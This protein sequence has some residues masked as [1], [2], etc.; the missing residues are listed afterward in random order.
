ML[1]DADSNTYLYY[2]RVVSHMTNGLVHITHIPE[3][4]I[5]SW[6]DLYDR[7]GIKIMVFRFNELVT[8]ANTHSTPM[9]RDFL[10]RIEV[11]TLKQTENFWQTFAKRMESGEY[12]YV[13][14]PWNMMTTFMMAGNGSSSLSKKYHISREG[15]GEL[16]YFLWVAI[17]VSRIKNEGKETDYKLF[18][19]TSD[20][21]IDEVLAQREDNTRHETQDNREKTSAEE[22]VDSED[23]ES[24]DG[25]DCHINDETDVESD[26]E[27][28]ED[29]CQITE[30]LIHKN[31]QLN[32]ESI[33]NQ[34][35]D[36]LITKSDNKS[37]TV[38][39]VGSD[40]EDNHINEDLNNKTNELND[41]LSD[42]QRGSELNTTYN[43]RK[44]KYTSIDSEDNDKE[45]EELSDNEMD[46]NS[47]DKTMSGKPSRKSGV[48]VCDYEGC[49]VS[50][51]DSYFL[52]RHAF[53]HL[54][55][56]IKTSMVYKRRPDGQYV[57]LM[58]AC[59]EVYK[60]RDALR[61]HQMSH[62]KE[63]PQTHSP[64]ELIEDNE[65]NNHMNE[66][67]NNKTNE[68]NDNSS[69][70][71]NASELN[72]TYNTRKRKYTSMDSEDND[73]ESEEYRSDLSDNFGDEWTV[74]KRVRKGPNGKFV[75]DYRGCGR[76]FNFS[77]CLR[78]HA[79]KHLNAKTRKLML[80]EKRSD[81]R[82]VCLMDACNGVYKQFRNL[83][84]HQ[85]LHLKD[86]PNEWTKE[87]DGKYVC[88]Y[89]GCDRHFPDVSAL[90]SHAFCHLN[91]KTKKSL[92]FKK[93][94]DGRYACLMDAC[95]TVYKHKYN[96]RGHQMSHLKEPFA[97]NC[98]SDLSD[99][100]MD[101]KSGDEVVGKKWPPKGAD[102]KYVCDYKGCDREF[103][104]VRSLKMH[105]FCHLNAK[106]KKSLVF[107]KRSDGR[108]ACLMDACNAVYKHIQHL[109]GHQMSH[110]KEPF[111]DYY[112]SDL[113][114]NEMDDHWIGWKPTRKAPDN[115]YVCDYR[116]CGTSFKIL[117][118]LRKHAFRHL[119]AKLR[120]TLA[121]KRRS[122][123]IYV[124]F[125]GECIKTYKTSG[126]MKG[127]VMSHLGHTLKVVD[128]KFVCKYKDC[129]RA[130]R[131]A[132]L[133]KQHAFCHLSPNIKT[134]MVFKIRPD[135][136]IVCL[137][138]ACNK[139]YEQMNSLRGHQISHLK[140]PYV[141]NCGSDLGDNEMDDKCDDHWIGW[142][143]TRKPDGQYVCDYRG[144][145]KLCRTRPEILKHAFS[146]LSAKLKKSL[147]FKTRSDG[148]Y[149][150]LW[151][152]CIKT[153]K[154]IDEIKG[155]VMSHLEDPLKWSQTCCRN[156]LAEELN[157]SIDSQRVSELNTK[158]NDN[159]KYKSAESDDNDSE[160]E[161]YGSGLSDNEMDDK[162][163]D[164][165][166]GE[167]RLR[168]RRNG[169]YV[170]DYR[171]CGLQF[172]KPS[173]LRRHSFTHLT[174]KAKK[175]FI[176]KRRSDG[177]FVCLMG[178]CNAVFK[179]IDSLR[180]HQMSH[181]REP[182]KC[183]QTDCPFVAITRV[184]L[185]K[186]VIIHPKPYACDTCG[187]KFRSNG[188]LT[189]HKRRH[190]D[191]LKYRCDWPEC[192]RLFSEKCLLRDH[193]NTHTK[194]IKGWLSIGAIGQSVTTRPQIASLN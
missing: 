110:L 29:N 163:G 171:G 41:N 182:L 139:V 75:C 80:F 126:E 62:L 177:Q 104:F 186:H 82:Y 21:F 156:E 64:N 148:I 150:C 106:T 184:A 152:E 54:S 100:E 165:W 94:S 48:F 105:A 77:S 17:R 38:T 28:N 135:N 16:P 65:D 125:W 88:H 66:D 13:N 45:S 39:G 129:G 68:L 179:R 92:V 144:C 6:Q 31:I 56:K 142:K 193:V 168:K 86:R 145:G 33:E 10:K 98:G 97:D 183:P 102:G 58:D 123:G 172:K 84:Q 76:A 130:F 20:E 140:A 120:K 25:I 192:G 131:F 166:M 93:R 83:R 158:T 32:R 170:C 176:F 191:A 162:S 194:C 95:N 34:I 8:Y 138:N 61:L 111:A 5:D 137:M 59:N 178:A 175:S 85:I 174:A 161:E 90:K 160:T 67:L 113:S 136:R 112:E 188:Y 190:N 36:D 9:A 7:P 2:K 11:I 108:Y 127:H 40:A 47:S 118:E 43:T 187:L 70:N 115:K 49:D 157:E 73:S 169:K 12:A 134:S 167:K 91:A 26:A 42:N 132:F 146:H 128:G 96:L 159:R 52:K 50:F 55:A 143:P 107:E 63:C 72:T 116:A 15:G 117:N 155:H 180:G 57:C 3:Q 149:V 18:G 103:L 124:C 154:A 22:V 46:A 109:R 99:D 121:F 69:G 133:L 147:A 60:Y 81:G 23:N 114:D 53:C 1:M 189:Q 119:S 141:D 27:D 37:T 185:Q 87:P 51:R 14:N 24:N 79:F 71:Q 4:R 78:L 89:K 164:E 181:L 151:G 173:Q 101:D 30:D 44:R 74:R 35:V 153:Y 19:Q 122:D